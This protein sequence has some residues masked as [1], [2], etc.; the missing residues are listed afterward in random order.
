MNIFERVYRILLRPSAEWKIIDEERADLSYLLNIYIAALAAIPALT[1]GAAATGGVAAASATGTA[2][3]A[4]AGVVTA[5]GQPIS[6]RPTI[7]ASTSGTAIAEAGAH[8]TDTGVTAPTAVAALA[9]SA[10]IT[11]TGNAVVGDARAA[12]TAA[13]TDPTDPAL[14][15]DRSRPTRFRSPGASSTLVRPSISTSM[16]RSV[17]RTL[18]YR[19]PDVSKNYSRPVNGCRPSPVIGSPAKNIRARSRSCC[20]TAGSFSAP[21]LPRNIVSVSR[22]SSSKR[23]LLTDNPK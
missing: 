1:A 3:P 13:T 18:V 20:V 21:S 8:T 4:R 17:A 10:A 16:R 14:A 2:G 5:E 23:T 9:A 7:T 22:A 19:S 6:A 12:V 15:V 11:A